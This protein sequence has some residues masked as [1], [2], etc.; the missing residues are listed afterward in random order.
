MQSGNA[1]YLLDVRGENELT[2]KGL[3]R[4]KRISLTQLPEQ[5]AS[6]PKDKPVVTLCRSGRRSMI[7]AS[8]LK[9]KGWHDLGVLMGGLEAWKNFDCEIEL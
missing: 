7:A 9:Q 8:F 4:A 1:P 6:I 3:K 5:L 2:G